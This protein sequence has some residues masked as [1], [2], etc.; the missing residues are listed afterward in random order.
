MPQSQSRSWA[1]DALDIQKLHDLSFK[2]RG[3][4]VAVIDTGVDI[5]HYDLQGCAIGSYNTTN[6]PY[7]TT[8]GHGTAV[9]GII[10]ARDNAG[11]II[12]IAPECKIYPI[13]AME[14]NG[15]GSYQFIEKAI[16]RAI[17]LKVDII[18]MSPWGVHTE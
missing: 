9:T 15:G 10:A 2:G 7:G 11:G 3:V 6:E 13:K 5:T 4:L 14:E 1:F 18:N 12:G 17:E 16:Y 8:H